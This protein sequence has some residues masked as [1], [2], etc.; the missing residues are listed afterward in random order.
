L[1]AAATFATIGLDW[2]GVIIALLIVAGV[3]IT[4][5]RGAR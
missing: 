4:G 1:I 2:G 5:V 3:L